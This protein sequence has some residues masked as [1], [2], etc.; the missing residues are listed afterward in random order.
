MEKS[1]LEELK[2][3]L[4]AEKEELER[5]LSSFSTEVSSSNWETKFPQFGQHTSEQDENVDEVEEY[6]NLL[7]VE[8]RLELQ[9]LDVNRA[10]EKIKKGKTYG[11]CENC[12]K[13]IEEKRLKIIPETKFCSK[14]SAQKE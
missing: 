10:L 1:F 12:G 3:K 11:I 13:K 9:L 14:C 2:Q 8:H 7:P 6:T 5:L 4:E